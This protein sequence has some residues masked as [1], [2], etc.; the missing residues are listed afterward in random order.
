MSRY[1]GRIRQIQLDPRGQPTAWI[2]CPPAAIPMPGQ[3]LQAWEDSNDQ[4]A[5]PTS[6]FSSQI[7]ET[8]FQCASP[9]R[10]AW[11]PGTELA[12]YGPLGHGFRLPAGVRR[13]ALAALGE[14]VLRLLPL[15][16]PALAQDA[17]VALFTDCPLP[18]LPAAVEVSPIAGLPTALA[19]ADLLALDLPLARLST[20][21]QALGM[22]LGGRLPCPAQALLLSPMPCSGMA[23]CGVCAVL[24]RERRSQKW[25]LVCQD[26]PVIDL[27]ALEW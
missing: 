13:L 14:S 9:I 21:R 8:G 26:G 24:S 3:Y 25:K 2:D 16:S 15:V 11:G 27:A 22:S 18:A 4:I 12:L 20:L 6:L 19:W 10:A 23:E 5:L 17:A 7:S 1:T